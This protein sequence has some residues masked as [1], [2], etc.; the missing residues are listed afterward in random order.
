M[1]W[2]EELELG[3]LFTGLTI[4]GVLSLVA[5]IVLMP[6][7]VGRMPADYFVGERPHRLRRTPARVVVHIAK[8]VLG[9]VLILAG[10]LMLVLPGQGLLTIL[11]GVVL[12]EGPGK[13][14]LERWLVRKPSI[15]KALNWLRARR[16]VEP[17]EIPE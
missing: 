12:T 3:W 13:Y 4:L 8:N 16:G 1:S 2:I 7:F 15:A 11:I 17:F 14:H 10:V 5:T 6:W 9:V